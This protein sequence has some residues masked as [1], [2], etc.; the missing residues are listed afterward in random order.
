[1]R[2]SS[3]NSTI[4]NPQ[5]Q[6]TWRRTASETPHNP[7][8]GITPQIATRWGRTWR[9]AAVSGEGRQSLFEAVKDLENADQQC[10]LEDAADSRRE[11]GQPDLGTGARRGVAGSSQLTD[12]RRVQSRDAG[13]AD[14]NLALT[15]GEEGCNSLSSLA[16]AVANDQSAG[17]L[18][19]NYV[20]RSALRD[21][22]RGLLPR[23][24]LTRLGGWPGFPI[25]CQG[26]GYQFIGTRG[27]GP[28]AIR[29]RLRQLGVCR[30]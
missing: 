28:V 16:V 12:S 11:L 19:N 20:A 10:G 4:E 17:E 7:E 24:R 26:Q 30:W 8:L 5:L 6:G 15:A 3:R 18:Q 22:H 23:C 13:H 29:H 9:A 14:E 25:S 27:L 2:S 21:F 1:M